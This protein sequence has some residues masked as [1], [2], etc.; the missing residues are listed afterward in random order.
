[1]GP[2]DAAAGVFWGKQD[3]MD[4]KKFYLSP[5]GRVNRKQFWLWLVLP[6]TVIGVLLAL[7]DIATGNYNPETGIG[8]FT[9]IF[10]LLTL[11]PTIIVYIKRFHDRDKSG[12]WVLIGLIPVIGVIWLLIELGFLKGTPGPNRFGPPVTD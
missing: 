10:A 7:V 9:G 8:L 3:P 6:L 5:E 12:W 1:M 11:I 4:F 2:A